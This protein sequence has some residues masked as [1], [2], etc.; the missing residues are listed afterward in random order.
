MYVDKIN[1]L[2]RNLAI[3]KIG[4][5][6]FIYLIT[7]GLTLILMY[8]NATYTLNYF[9]FHFFGYLYFG[10]IV[11]ELFSIDGLKAK[12]NNSLNKYLLLK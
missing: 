12:R 5:R 3:Q 7:I 8:I 10:S 2:S 1:K 9:L 6:Y 4:F 11:C